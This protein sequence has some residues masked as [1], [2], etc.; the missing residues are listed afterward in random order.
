MTA[1]ILTCEQ[2]QKKANTRRQSVCQV[3]LEGTPVAAQVPAGNVACCDRA[4]H[5]IT[6]DILNAGMNLKRA[7]VG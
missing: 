1:T 6:D 4:N 3:G 7:C 5:I 2:N